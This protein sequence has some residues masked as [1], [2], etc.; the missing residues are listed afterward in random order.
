MIPGAEPPRLAP[1]PPGSPVPGVFWA[2]SAAFVDELAEALAG[3]KVLEIFA[4][5]GYLA[6]LLAARGLEVTATSVL[7]SMDAHERG[8]YHPVANLDAREAVLRLG[9]DHDLLLMCWPTVT[10]AALQ[11]CELWGAKP[12]AFIGEWT[13][14]SKNHLGGCATDELFE[15][16]A[17]SRILSSYRGNL[18]E[19]AAIGTLGPAP[20]PA[21]RRPK[22]LL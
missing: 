3:R 11:A 10:P 13:D 7:S 20:A 12:I 4:G 17:P 18:L 6:S 22:S 1:P 5:N 8:L 2:A 9:D 21:P 16:L 15:R 14:Y 19:R